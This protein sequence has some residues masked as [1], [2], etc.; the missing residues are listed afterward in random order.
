MKF[1]FTRLDLGG[2]P[3]SRFQASLIAG[4]ALDPGSTR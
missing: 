4:D 3:L 2:K 1:D